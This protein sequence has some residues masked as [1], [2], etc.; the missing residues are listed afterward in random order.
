MLDLDA[1][2]PVHLHGRALNKSR[3]SNGTHRRL[4]VE[5]GDLG[6]RRSKAYAFLKKLCQKLAWGVNPIPHI[7]YERPGFVKTIALNLL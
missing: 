7:L 1:T 5:G 4:D 3:R 2:R 6:V